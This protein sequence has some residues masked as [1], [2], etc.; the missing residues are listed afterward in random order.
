[1]VIFIWSKMFIFIKKVVN[2][3]RP[4]CTKNWIWATLEAE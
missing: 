2:G 3:G 1:M 4:S